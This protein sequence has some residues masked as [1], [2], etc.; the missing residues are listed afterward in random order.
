MTEHSDIPSP[1]SPVQQAAR[2]FI[3]SE[4]PL[5]SSLGLKATRISEGE[6]SF[7]LTVPA[8]YS[9]GEYVHSGIMAIMLDTILGNAV[10]TSL[11]RFVPIATI[12]L[13]TDYFSKVAPDTPLICSGIC[14]GIRDDVA[15][16][17]GRA[18]IE[19]SGE[20]VAMAAGTFM[21]GTR[22]KSKSRL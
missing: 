3:E 8:G 7:R 9:D 2:A 1:L 5:F 16:S 18:M 14:E 11:D 19:K 15:Y 12:N 17:T 20:L 6:I 21:V 22:S 13:K 10:W 4:H